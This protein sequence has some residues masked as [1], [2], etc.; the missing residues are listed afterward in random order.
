MRCVATGA[1][2]LLGLTGLTS[3]LR[4]DVPPR[5][6]STANGTFYFPC[7]EHNS[8][9]FVPFFNAG[10][11][12]LMARG[13]DVPDDATCF[14]DA[15]PSDTTG[16][17][18]DDF[19][20]WLGHDLGYFML[21]QHGTFRDGHGWV[22]VEEYFAQDSTYAQQR[23][24][25][26]AQAYGHND[27]FY[28]SFSEG[29]TYVFISVSE[30]MVRDAAVFGSGV[31]FWDDCWSAYGDLSMTSAA[32]D[33]GAMSA[34]GWSCAAGGEPVVHGP[35]GTLCRMCG[36][37]CA[38]YAIF[39]DSL[40]NYMA[41]EA[42]N[43]VG[44]AD[45]V[46]DH[47]SGGD[48]VKLYNSP[49]VVGLAAGFTAEESPIPFLCYQYG[50]TLSGFGYAVPPDYPYNPGNN[51][52]YPGNL[53]AARL[54]AAPVGVEVPIRI[55]F[56]SPMDTDA[57]SFHVY[58]RAAEHDDTVTCVT[59]EWNSDV[60]D[61]QEWV[62]HVVIPVDWPVDEAQVPESAI[63]YVDARDAFK[64]DINSTLD[65]DGDGDSEG[66]D[67]NHRF[68]VCVTN[69]AIPVTHPHVPGQQ[70][71]GGLQVFMRVNGNPEFAIHPRMKVEN[72]GTSGGPSDS[73][74]VVC[75]VLKGHGTMS[76]DTMYADTV[77]TWVRPESTRLVRF[78]TWLCR[79]TVPAGDYQAVFFHCVPGDT[80]TQD[81]TVRADF[82]L[83]DTTVRPAPTRD[84]DPY[85]WI[86]RDPAGGDLTCNFQYDWPRNYPGWRARHWSPYGSCWHQERHDTDGFMKMSYHRQSPHCYDSLV[87]PPIDCRTADSVVLTLDQHYYAHF[88]PPH[89]PNPTYYHRL[90][91]INA[92]DCSDAT[93]I[94][95]AVYDCARYSVPWAVGK[96]VMFAW[97]NHGDMWHTDSWNLD[98]V[99]VKLFPE[100]DRDV[101]IERITYPIGNLTAGSTVNPQLVLRNSGDV[102]ESCE[103]VMQIGQQYCDTL[104]LVVPVCAR[105]IVE[106]KPW[107]VSSQT[108]LATAHLAMEYADFR[109]ENDTAR[110][111]C[112][113]L[114]NV[115][116]LEGQ[117]PLGQI[118]KGCVMAGHQGALHFRGI[119]NGPTKNVSY[120]WLPPPV[121]NWDTIAW[122]KV[123]GVNPTKKWPS[124][125]S[126]R[127][128]L[129]AVYKATKQGCWMARYIPGEDS[130]RF[131]SGRGLTGNIGLRAPLCWDGDD[132]I[133]TINSRNGTALNLIA[134]CISR[135]SWLYVDTVPSK[136]AQSRSKP[137]GMAYLDGALYILGMCRGDSG[138]RFWRYDIAAESCAPLRE[139][140]TGSLFKNAIA[141]V[142]VSGCLYALCDPPSC[143]GGIYQYLPESDSWTWLVESPRPIDKSASLAACG[144]NLYLVPSYDHDVFKYFM[145]EGYIPQG[146]PLP[147]MGF[148]MASD[149]G[150][151]D[152][153]A[154][155]EAVIDSSE[156]DPEPVSW[157]PADTVFVYA[158]E[159]SDGLRGLCLASPDGIVTS[160]SVGTLQPSRP[161]W[162]PDGQWIAFM[163]EDVNGSSDVWKC[164]PDGADL[165]Q[166]THDGCCAGGPCWSPGSQFIAFQRED[167][168]SSVICRVDSG[169]DNCI[170][171]T[172]TLD[173]YAESPT[174]TAGGDI[175]YQSLRDGEQAS[176]WLMD[177]AGQGK[178]ELRGEAQGGSDCI[179]PSV[180]PEGQR[181][182]YVRTS[183][184]ADEVWIDS[185]GVS[186][187]YSHLLGTTSSGEYHN[188]IFSPD[189]R[190]VLFTESDVYGSRV[191]EVPA[192]G[193]SADALTG[194]S[195][196][197]S[198]QAPS[199]NGRWVAGQAVDTSTSET[200]VLLMRRYTGDSISV[201]TLDTTAFD[202]TVDSVRIDFSI[203]GNASNVAL[204]VKQ[205]ATVVRTL[206][207]AA[208][209]AGDYTYYWNGRCT[210]DT[211]ALP[212]SYTVYLSATG[213][214]WTDSKS[215]SAQVLG[216]QVNGGNVS[217]TWT[218]AGS[219]YV[220]CGNLTIPS[221]D[222]LSIGA[223][224]KVMPAG[225]YSV[226][227]A[228]G[229][230]LI[231]KG[232]SGNRILFSPYRKLLPVPDSVASASWQG[233]LM[234]SGS[235]VCTLDY[236]VL[237]YGGYGDCGMV[238][239]HDDDA[240][241]SVTHSVLR[242]GSS[243][244]I[245]VI[246]ALL[247]SI[248]ISNDTFVG[249]AAGLSAWRADRLEPLT[250][251]CW[252][253]GNYAQLL[254]LPSTTSGN[255]LESNA[256]WY[257]C[258]PGMEISYL[259][260]IK[261]YPSSSGACTLRLKPG[262][263]LYGNT[264]K[265]IIVGSSAG[266][267]VGVLLAEGKPDSWVTLTGAAWSGIEVREDSGYT[268]KFRYC[269]IAGDLAGGE[270][271]L[272]LE[273]H[274]SAR[275][276]RCSLVNC[277]ASSG[278]ARGI[279]A[280]YHSSLEATQTYFRNN[281]VG[282]DF[283][284]GSVGD[285][286]HLSIKRCQFAYNDTGVYVSDHAVPRVDSSNFQDNDSFSVCNRE[287]TNTLNAPH[288][289]WGS[290]GG[291]QGGD[292]TYRVN[293][294]PYSTSPNVI[295]PPLDV[296]AR[297]PLFV[298]PGSPFSASRGDQPSYNGSEA[299]SAAASGH[300][301]RPASFP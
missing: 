282:I 292:V 132:R 67:T 194:W 129:Y 34:F 73:F 138:P 260:D 53:A 265:S 71:D 264:G 298:T 193:G 166:L 112:C 279:Y 160:V 23:T 54:R 224:V 185:I 6:P 27:W 191:V 214:G 98:N 297:W 211:L 109:P 133:Y 259:Q 24:Q 26:L 266:S 106:F 59:D 267:V 139:Y 182:V 238:H 204:Q 181:L 198:A 70:F 39:P 49:R 253:T 286:N 75:L 235:P 86:E 12:V 44:L 126:A 230:K 150:G 236:C 74:P 283:A 247:P 163:G 31:V 83:K 289:W 170:E 258:G 50:Y 68:A 171:L 17:R 122:F 208:L 199:H 99:A 38:F 295:M 121:A 284:D 32:L 84:P 25:Q 105:G 5:I 82:I 202:A 147:S 69:V 94:D 192:D 18:V 290:A 146:R 300:A 212:G 48:S 186:P 29:D 242:G 184:D 64:G 9:S 37:N 269:R 1:A 43:E 248:G 213:S 262:V 143:A 162:S 280:T 130:W 136:S 127:D 255:Q 206:I 79:D 250:Q 207:N 222:S 134:Y 189:G 232:S 178:T 200:A 215:A 245:D 249:N 72:L 40:T 2:I 110:D 275:V 63:V 123:D 141:L 151:L 114:N 148:V 47:C 174:W 81:D 33:A 65:T 179:E 21:F 61:N 169:G 285:S 217:A 124:M 102:D 45:L 168:N 58:L 96:R 180:S 152:P 128:T 257:N 218:A 210:G 244:G 20:Y 240:L 243:Y 209:D 56:S 41:A 87:T 19:Y 167:G 273:G 172:S 287:G 288:C 92:D 111:S 103:V 254:W 196:D 301:R 252:F 261:V 159:D 108:S 97:V 95:S 216:T 263:T 140:T 30:K 62:G 3:S 116:A 175:V 14:K 78:G 276:D 291:P 225:C 135:D 234:T 183:S 7:N 187:P 226:T 13:W 155:P 145:P 77:L 173:G 10:R 165:M 188:P 158:R 227:I 46:L 137:I 233:I 220:I 100:A 89:D 15:L 120:L 91:A 161:A 277:R 8:A 66:W 294:E 231:A 55:L 153:G 117:F 270:A 164:R 268:S 205:G 281:N 22:A 125:V 241:V 237:E 52:D 272:Y 251:T 57:D 176:V 60:F 223:G 239:A 107:L 229:G 221:G 293:Y 113:G 35:V 11:D 177:S 156:A 157:S 88:W 228:T 144:D 195:D 219:P 278:A 80:N 115:F 101:A 51:T 104:A 28:C 190:Y 274:A 246:D 256:T 197:R 154:E 203:E 36:S 4:A 142:P 118:K 201:F 131:V 16:P 93:V 299:A 149:G 76:D 85:V 271:G 90:Y 296:A 119:T 42:F